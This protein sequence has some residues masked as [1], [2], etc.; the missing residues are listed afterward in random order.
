MS[1]GDVS[2]GREPRRGARAGD[3]QGNLAVSGDGRCAVP[4]RRRVLAGRRRQSAAHHLH[5]RPAPDRAR[6]RDRAIRPA[7][8]NGGEVDMVVPYNSVPLVYRNVVVV[9]ANTPPGSP[10][11]S[12]IRGRSMRAPAPS[13]GNSARCRSRDRSVTTRGKATAGR[14]ASAS[15]RGRSTS[16]W[17]SARGLLYMPLASP[18]RRVRRRP[19]GREPVR[20]LRRR[21]RYPD[22]RVQVAF[23]DHPSRSLG[24]RSARAA[25]TVRHRAERTHGSRARA[26]HQVRLHVHPEPRNRAADLRCRRAPGCE[27]RRSGREAFATQ[28][29]PV[30]PPPIARS[31]YRPEDLVTASDTTPEHARACEELVDSERRRLQRRARSRRGRIA[32]RA[33]PPRTALGFPG[34]ARRRELGRDGLRSAD[35]VHLRRHPGQRRPRLDRAEP[36]TGRR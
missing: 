11:A 27:E 25:G 21:S 26:D 36:G 13:C 3:R 9:G 7:F 28:P 18:I 10:A 29:F 8:G 6:R 31:S 20:Q 4:S 32:R 2:A 17:T 30:K 5:G 12:A 22:R 35:R 34:R 33:P 16:R 15:T 1:S 24:R 19:E 23:P 14:A